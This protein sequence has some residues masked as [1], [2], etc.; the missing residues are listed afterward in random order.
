MWV[1]DWGPSLMERRIT[2]QNNNPEASKLCHSSRIRVYDPYSSGTFSS[3][4]QLHMEGVLKTFSL[5]LKPEQNLF[6]CGYYYFN[7][8][9]KKL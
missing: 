2:F 5:N 3:L 7:P 1:V 9:N 6:C 4:H 8:L